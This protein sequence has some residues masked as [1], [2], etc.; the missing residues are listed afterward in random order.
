[1]LTTRLIQPLTNRR[2]I[3]MKKCLL[4]LFVFVTAIA[5]TSTTFAATFN[6][7]TTTVIGGAIFKPSAKVTVS[8]MA[9]GNNWCG[10]AQHASSDP[11]KDGKQHAMIST[12]PQI[13]TI[14]AVGTTPTACTATNAFPSGF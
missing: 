8:A 4:I 6:D 7:T 1:M 9:S 3:D 5:F 2:R 14:A 11:A 13:R 10:S 12:D